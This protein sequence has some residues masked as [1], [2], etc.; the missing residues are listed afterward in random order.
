MIKKR[1]LA[2]A[3]CLG[4]SQANAERNDFVL[5]LGVGYGLSNQ[6]VSTWDVSNQ[7]AASSA[8]VLGRVKVGV[9]TTPVDALFGFGQVGRLRYDAQEAM[10]DSATLSLIGVGYSHYLKPDV[11]S[12]FFTLGVGFS[13]Y[14]AK[15]GGDELVNSGQAFLLETGYE[16][17]EHLQLSSTLMMSRMADL[18]WDNDKYSDVATT[19]ISFNIEYKL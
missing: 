1:M 19:S 9:M 4:A 16:V 3:V 14:Q 6:S 12:P 13:R 7:P 15:G 5:N 18:D 11:G 8:G 10:V 2:I 17:Y